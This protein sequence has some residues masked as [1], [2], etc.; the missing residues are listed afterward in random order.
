LI[1][2]L[3]NSALLP[4][5]ESNK[6]LS[7]LITNSEKDLNKLKLG[8]IEISKQAHNFSIGHFTIF[9][10]TEREDL[11]GHNFQLH[12]N[13]TAVLGDDGLIFD[14]AILKGLMRDLCD[15]IDEKTIL[16]GRSPHL[17]IGEQ[18]GY[19]SA[20][21]NK[22]KLLFLKRDVMVLDISNTTIEEFAHYFLNILVKH[23]DLQDRG[24]EGITVK[25][26]SNP[27]QQG[28]ASWDNE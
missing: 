25:I 26:S 10:S 3:N 6:V 4:A 28:V 12:C 8:Q 7:T 2:R 24:I 20:I 9:S 27:G 19:V 17:K 11:H 21:F 1:D 13:V 14:Y 16:P 23:P 15:E 18:D 22:E 5:P